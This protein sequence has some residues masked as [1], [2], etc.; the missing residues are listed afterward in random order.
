MNPSSRVK[1]LAVLFG[2]IF[3]GSIVFLVF[4][5]RSEET[6]SAEE[7][8]TLGRPAAVKGKAPVDERPR[9]PVCGKEL[10]A[11][12]ECPYCLMKK[13]SAADGKDDAPP[14]RLGRYLAWSL[15]GLTIILGAV[16][17]GMYLRA[18]QRFLRHGGEEQ[19]LKTKC[20]NC[21]R[22]VRFAAHLAGAFGSCPTCKSRIQ[23]NPIPDSYY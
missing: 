23:F 10:P 6:S 12:G 4:E 20:T 17:I 15:V 21:K 7:K 9:C 19:Q 3:L 1:L 22:R 11:S 16:H 13:R 2:L 14:P 18:R 8:A 5:G